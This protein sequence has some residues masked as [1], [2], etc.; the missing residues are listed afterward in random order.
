MNEER[1]SVLI[2][3]SG[4]LGSRYLQG[5]VGCV[6]RLH[7]HVNDPSNGARRRAAE[8]WNEAGGADSQHVVSYHDALGGVATDLD[9]V[10]VATTSNVRAA[11]VEEVATKANVTGWILEKVLA[12]SDR[13]LE[14]ITATV[15]KGGRSWVNTW[16]RTTPW[17][18]QIRDQSEGGP[19]DFD[20]RG[21]SWGL[22]CNGIHVL[23]LMAWWTGEDLIAVDVGGLD[24][25]WL[26]AKRPGFFEPSGTLEVAYSGG[27]VGRLTAS[28]PASADKPA[29]TAIPEFLRIEGYSTRWELERPFSESMGRAVEHN[30]R[31]ILGR[32]EYQ[33]ERTA[34]LVD[35]ILSTGTCDLPDLSASTR[36]HRILLG[37][38]LK[39]WKATAGEENESV[40]IT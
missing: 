36:L 23:D 38:L 40:P 4:Q 29:G 5:L 25:A 22:G 11:V 1:F 34:P 9:L 20:I 6:N 26:P 39:H 2:A 30:G 17:Y 12:Q 16:A 37:G 15:G 13:D 3:G 7:I 31:E 24:K 21:G 18:R 14:R 35:S 19:V 33:S 28:P 10:I 32:V 8:R 27:T